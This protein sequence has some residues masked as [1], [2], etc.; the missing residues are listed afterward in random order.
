MHTLENPT[1]QD[2]ETPESTENADQF[3]DKEPE[4]MNPENEDGP[5]PEADPRFND[6][7]RATYCPED[8]KLRLYVG[9]VP[10]AEY[11][12]LRAEGW[13][14]T[15]KQE[16]DFV[17]TWTPQRRDAATAYAGI[18]E[19]EDQ[20][21]EDRA[22]D[23]AERFAGYLGK[24]I[25]DATGH[26]DRYG[27]RPSAHGFQ[28]QRKAETSA[29]RHDRIGTRAV[30]AWGK[31]EY[32]QRRTAG[33]IS[34]AL[35]KCAPGVRMGRIKVLEADLRRATPGGQWHIHLTLR[36]AY[37]NQMLEAQGGRLAHVEIEAGGT[38]GGKLILK[39]NK[40]SVTGRVTSVDLKGPKVQGWTYK[41]QNIPGT[42][43]A[44]Y[45]FDTERLPSN[46]YTPPTDESRAELAAFKA[47]KKAAAPK[48]AT[49]PLV[50][51]TDEDAERLQAAWNEIAK[52]EAEKRKARHGYT[53]EH[54]PTLI[55]RLTQ[56]E[57]SAASKGSYARVSTREVFPGGIECDNYHDALRKMRELHGKEV[58]QIR[59]TYGGSYQASRVI[60]LTDKPQKPLP[61]EVWPAPTF[62][63]DA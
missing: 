61:A 32:W 1:P 21:P 52:A 42:E 9:R 25:S 6:T 18:I 48:V 60:V 59:R 57:Y 51:P 17:T 24:R 50:N 26:A 29:R 47:E 56:A 20:G 8:N 33:V 49:I 38:I 35:Y 13:T 11:E 12:A 27:S 62:T 45:Q 43:F 30:D 4:P 53:E 7:N 22:A 34:H 28:S 40:S 63:L 23:R 10:R 3:L 58:C 37:E 31:A 19:D 54:K 36:L 44:A 2:T 5:E 15:P 16:C 39:V 46:A 14:S 41:A 55:L